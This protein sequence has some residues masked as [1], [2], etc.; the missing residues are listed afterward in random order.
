MKNKCLF[1]RAWIGRCNEDAIENGYCE[2]HKDLFCSSCGKKATHDCAETAGF[3]CGAPLCDDCEHTICD[4]GC[5]SQGRLPEGLGTH[6]K[7][8]QQVYFSWIVQE[9]IDEHGKEAYEKLMKEVI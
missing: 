9:Y 3:V 1:N 7:K 6:C 4:N 5:N 8:D 2:K